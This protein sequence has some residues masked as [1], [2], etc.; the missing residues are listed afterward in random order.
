MIS[1]TDLDA[2]LRLLN[3]LNGTIDLRSGKLRPHQ[4]ENYMTCLAPV[5]YDP[6]AR[7]PLWRFP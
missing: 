6:D 2:Y 4:R 3:V 7:S 5:R 1:A